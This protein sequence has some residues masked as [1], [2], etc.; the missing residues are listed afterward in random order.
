MFSLVE[1]YGLLRAACCL[2]QFIMQQNVSPITDK[3]ITINIT[4]VNITLQMKPVHQTFTNTKL[5]K[6]IHRILDSA[7]SYEDITLPNC[8]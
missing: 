5:R 8:V 6:T 3:Q 7:C 4:V 2:H 1:M